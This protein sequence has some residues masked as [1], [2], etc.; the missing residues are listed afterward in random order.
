[1]CTA[2]SYL[3]KCHYFGR[4]LDFEHSFGEK[5]V[6]TSKKFPFTFRNQTT[7]Q[8]H[9]AIV[10]MGIVSDNFPLYFDAVNDAGL[11]MAGLLFPGYAYYHKPK[12]GFHN[13]ASFELIPWV[14]SCCRNIQ[15]AKTLL[16]KTNV[17]D[18]DFSNNYP[19]TPLHWIISDKSGSLTVESLREGLFVYDN[20][21]GV[22][23][24]SP[25]FP[26]QMLI[27]SNFMSLSPNPPENL[28]SDKLSFTHYSRGMGSIGLPGD[29]SSCS[30]FVRS[31]FTKLNST[32][33]EGE[34]FSVNQVFHIL[35]NVF[36]IRGCNI[37]ENT[38]Q[39]THYS[40]CINSDKGIYYYTTYD[41]SDLNAVNIHDQDLDSDRIYTFELITD[42]K[43]HF[44][45]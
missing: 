9:Y 43:L 28:F 10:G 36:Q 15:E 7:L 42:W 32:S 11:S 27:L 35:R 2:V 12:D 1:M 4:N 44:Q 5:I 20:P 23:S 13:I 18:I 29:L 39:I 34:Q 6:I 45:R 37:V 40:S 16:E 31:A 21:V 33:P 25:D 30:R 22:L 8:T 14:L 26:T 38:P 19:S 17:T 24:N 3:S 41:N